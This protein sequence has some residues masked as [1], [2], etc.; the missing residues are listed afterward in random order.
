MATCNLDNCNNACLEDENKC[1]LHCEKNSWYKE[2]LIGMKIWEESEDKVNDFWNQLR[3]L[4]N[5]FRRSFKCF[6]FNQIIFPKMENNSQ[7]KFNFFDNILNLEFENEVVFNNC[8]FLDDADFSK[9]IFLKSLHIDKDTKFDGDVILND[10]IIKGTF[11]FHSFN[12]NSLESNFK[13]SL[14]CK[15]TVFDGECRINNSNLKN[16][17]LNNAEFKSISKF[18]N[19]SF[20]NLICLNTLFYDTVDFSQSTNNRIQLD[21]TVF[22]KYTNFQDVKFGKTLNLNTTTKSGEMNFLNIQSKDNSIGLVDIIENR[23][24]ARIIKDSFEKQNNIIEANKYY[25]IE[26]IK[27]E[28]E[29]ENEKKKNWFEWL[30]FKIHGISS[31]HSQDALLALFWIINFGFIGSLFDCFTKVDYVSDFITFHIPYFIGS[32]VMILAIIGVGDI[33][34]EYKKTY[35]FFIMFGLYSIYVFNS[36]D[37]GLTDLANVINPFSIMTKGDTLNLGML[38]FKVIIA[39]LMYQFIVSV[40]QNTRRK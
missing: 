11:Y 19:S 26:M 31:N 21:Y 35:K 6:I 38:I 27:R 22:I 14:W 10:A 37:Y 40:R 36:E 7:N 4:I 3:V 5:S 8:I 23:E 28:E 29:L 24:T 17:Y 16:I 2:P 1:I 33:I 20:N 9:I 30:V 39:Y 15:R 25:A 13:G 32:I 18:N 34:K 12:L